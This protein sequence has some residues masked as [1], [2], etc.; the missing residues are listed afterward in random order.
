MCFW[1]MKPR[2]RSIETV[3]L[4][5]CPRYRHDLLALYGVNS[6]V[7]F[8]S[9]RNIHQQCRNTWFRI[10]I[11]LMPILSSRYSYILI[12]DV[13]LSTLVWAKGYFKKSSKQS[14][15]EFNGMRWDTWKAS[16]PSWWRIKILDYES[17]PSS[18][19]YN[20]V[21]H[22]AL[23]TQCRAREGGKR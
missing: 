4:K 23:A 17:S 19:E 10:K 5:I 21:E 1:Y 7:V 16:F 13:N 22:S 3:H 20:W 14:N 9:C 8:S 2:N 11:V 12:N 18:G 6:R 15:L